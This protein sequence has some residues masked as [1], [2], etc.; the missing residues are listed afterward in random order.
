MCVL[1]PIELCTFN[2]LIT[3]FVSKV[4]VNGFK[5]DFGRK[6]AAS[7]HERVVFSV[8]FVVNYDD[9]SY[10]FTTKPFVEQQFSSLE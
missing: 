1:S 6:M 4:V 7:K 3:N 10:E 8:I 5:N 2:I 9:E